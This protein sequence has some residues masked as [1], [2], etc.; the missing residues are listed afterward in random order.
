[1]LDIIIDSI[2]FLLVKVFYLQVKPAASPGL[3]GNCT[4]VPLTSMQ[5]RYPLATP[6]MILLATYGSEVV[7]YEFTYVC[8]FCF[9]SVPGF[10]FYCT[11]LLHGS[12]SVQCWTQN[13]EMNLVWFWDSCLIML[14]VTSPADFDQSFA[15]VHPFSQCPLPQQFNDCAECLCKAEQFDC[16]EQIL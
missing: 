11:A 14:L 8:R 2:C 10:S 3:L 16:N 1:M 13:S 5:P 9:S 15:T 4:K 7:H 6:W 12:W